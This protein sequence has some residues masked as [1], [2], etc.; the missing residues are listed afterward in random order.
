MQNVSVNAGFVAA[1]GQSIDPDQTAFLIHH[2]NIT[3]A[4]NTQ[5]NSNIGDGDLL[6]NSWVLDFLNLQPSDT[7][8][9]EPVVLG[10]VSGC[11]VE[12]TFVAYQS[13][14]NWDEL[15]HT[16]PLRIPYMWSKT[17][18][19][20]Y[21]QSVLERYA[22][23]LL[24]GAVLHQGSL[25]GMKVLDSLMV[26]RVSLSAAE[27][28][29]SAP[30]AV[31]ASPQFTY[32][33]M[34]TPALLTE[35]PSI[36]LS[37]SLNRA[38]LCFAPTVRNVLHL[39]EGVFGSDARPGG[40]V[41]SVLLSAPAGGGKSVLLDTVGNLCAE[42]HE[43]VTV[44][45]AS[46]KGLDQ[47]PDN[48]IN[49]AADTI[50][51]SEWDHLL[52]VLRALGM[53]HLV[54]KS[55][56][57]QTDSVLLCLDDMDAVFMHYSARKDDNLET[58]RTAEIY[59]QFG[60]QLS[61]LLRTLAQPNNSTRILIV[62]CT[63]KDP[64]QL[65]RAHTGCPEFEKC[66]AL[67]SP[68]YTE[69]VHILNKLLT[70]TGLVYQMNS[71]T[72]LANLEPAAQEP[73]A[74]SAEVQHAVRRDWAARL[75]ALSAGYLPGDLAA[76]V[77]RIV[78]LHRGRSVAMQSKMVSGESV[79][80]TESEERVAWNTALDAIVSVIP[81][82]LQ[83]LGVQGNSSSNN[84]SSSSARLSWRDFAGYTDLINDLKRRL[85][86]L[87]NSTSSGGLS[88]GKDKDNSNTAM[89]G[90]PPGKVLRLKGAVLRGIVLHG[91]SGCGKT[92]L[93]S[94]IT[95]ELKMNFVSVRST[96]L[97]S[98]YFGETESKIRD[99][100]HRAR[101]AAPC[102]LFF[103]D[104]DA[105]AHKRS[106]ADAS[107]SS[108]SSG[109]HG[110]ILSTFLNELDGIVSS[111]S[112][113]NSDNDIEDG[114]Q[115]KEQGSQQVLVIA[116]CQDIA[117]LD[118]ALVRP[119]RLQHHV[120]LHQPNAEDI[121]SILTLYASK[122]NCAADL[123][124]TQASAA[125]CELRATASEVESFARNA[126]MHAVRQ[127]VHALE[128]DAAQE[129]TLSDQ[130]SVTDAD[131]KVTQEHFDLAL[132]DLLGE[133]YNNNHDESAEASENAS[134]KAAAAA[135]V[136]KVELPSFEWS[137]GFSFGV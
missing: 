48:L 59:Q 25:I 127:K 13:Q 9:A 113:N 132:K 137:G 126:F 64:T 101:A 45:R 26:F 54:A 110:R 19:E 21:K 73:G 106:A 120:L 47:R 99:L 107:D 111:G 24:Q 56:S 30:V 92:L 31:L 134:I 32:R 66:F 77:Q 136:D 131:N 86:P 37:P 28:D 16:G 93:A 97:L 135:A 100:F 1:S 50:D 29:A 82:T 85:A 43:G 55:Q 79:V 84:N 95:S 60:Y 33:I 115:G 102:V 71:D 8:T 94:V 22:S 116:A 27:A 49:N 42:A 129:S 78:F 133:R 6:I 65:L 52:Q 57:M 117:N 17:W 53:E 98:R 46:C 69:R 68:T 108:T 7:I 41:K 44:L 118:E 80:K 76:V 11:R 109:L 96:D 15:S 62:G 58:G 121:A 70:D 87:A 39:C 4:F 35:E 67:C 130:S 75:A 38:L 51:T 90:A 128:Q 122:L 74:P 36:S 123:S 14:V 124:L 112:N 3:I 88:T 104:F 105:L 125:L 119:G 63:R 34:L 61:Q 114:E 18:P 5:A 40:F 20:N 2:N 10:P 89:E 12:L 91:P 83:Q 81:L 23:I 72:N 103:D